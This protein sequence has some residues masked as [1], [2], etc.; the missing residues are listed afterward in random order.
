MRKHWSIV[1]VARAPGTYYVSQS[2]GDDWSNFLAFYLVASISSPGISVSASHRVDRSLSEEKRGDTRSPRGHRLCVSR[3]HLPTRD[4]RSRSRY[5]HVSSRRTASLDRAPLFCVPLLPRF[6][7]L[8]LHPSLNNMRA[9]KPALLWPGS[10]RNVTF[11]FARASQFCRST[12]QHFKRQS[13]GRT[14]RNRQATYA[15]VTR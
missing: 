9:G 12:L 2:I 8:V 5:R 13:A 14:G 3:S 7:R 6:V 15:R 1:L 11:A 4:P 10:Q